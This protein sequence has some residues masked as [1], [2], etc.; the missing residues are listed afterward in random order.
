MKLKLLGKAK[1]DE[2]YIQVP[3]IIIGKGEQAKVLWLKLALGSDAWNN[4]KNEP[5]YIEEIPS[6]FAWLYRDYVIQVD[7]AEVQVISAEDVKLHI[8]HFILIRENRFVKMQKEVERFE[9]FEKF[10]PT[11]REQIPEEVRMYVWRR[12]EGKCA[13][14]H[15]NNNLEFDHIIPISKGGSNTERNIQLLCSEC[16][17][18]KSNDI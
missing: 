10:N 2:G 8:K 17:K 7:A 4:Q 16:N 14:C 11:Y 9:K 3:T 5:L 12:D 15:I 1:F 6:L 13:I 18:K